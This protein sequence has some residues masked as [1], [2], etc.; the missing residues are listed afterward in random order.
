MSAFKNR[1]R[2]TSLK[3]ESDKCF[4][5]KSGTPTSKIRV[6]FPREL[7]S[8]SSILS[9]KQAKSLQNEMKQKVE[10]AASA[11]QARS[12]KTLEIHVYTFKLF[13]RSQTDPSLLRG[14]ALGAHATSPRIE[15][16]KDGDH[17]CGRSYFPP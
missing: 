8:L 6:S 12:N 7:L 5:P 16:I 9:H 11:L 1:K 2:Q 17:S 4:T 10:R 3:A 13:N 14:V 15:E